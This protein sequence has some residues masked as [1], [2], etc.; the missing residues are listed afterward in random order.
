M[1]KVEGP[2]SSHPASVSWLA[3]GV[4]VRAIELDDGGGLALAGR[5]RRRFE[6]RHQPREHPRLKN[7]RFLVRHQVHLAFR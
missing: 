5:H 2:A 7:L 1:E 4:Q 3:S 6:P